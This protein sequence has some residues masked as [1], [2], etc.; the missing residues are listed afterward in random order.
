MWKKL[1]KS[2]CFHRET[3]RWKR[4]TQLWEFQLTSVQIIDFSSWIT[5]LESRCVC[6]NTARFLC[7]VALF[8][9]DFS[10]V[11]NYVETS[12]QKVWRQPPKCCW[13]GSWVCAAHGFSVWFLSSL[14]A[15]GILEYMC[16]PVC[17]VRCVLLGNGCL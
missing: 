13:T 10:F 16:A 17:V 5:D 6:P 3:A 1:T 12:T 8:G 9:Y 14:N 11:T 4:Y 2:S 15:D 7:S